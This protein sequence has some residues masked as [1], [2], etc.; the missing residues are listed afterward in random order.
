[1]YRYLQDSIYKIHVDGAWPRSGLD[2]SK[3]PGQQYLYDD[4]REGAQ[5]S[6]LTFLIYLNDDFT[7]GYTTFFVP[8]VM[9]DR[10]R[11]IRVEPRM[12]SALV[13]PHGMSMNALLHEGSGVGSGA[14][15]VIRTDVLYDRS[16]VRQ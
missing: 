12:G 10:L 5:L 15:Y 7:E 9:V 13:F 14:K 3:P 8:D 2:L 11:G 16:E 4:T 6:R 1:M